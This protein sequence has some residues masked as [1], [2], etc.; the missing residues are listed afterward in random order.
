[1]PSVRTPL[2][3]DPVTDKWA[4]KTPMR[5]ARLE[6]AGVT[7]QGKLYVIGGKNYFTEQELAKVEM[8]T[9]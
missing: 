4:T 3:S 8:Y 1:M 5:T 7:A 9:P 2:V 6:A